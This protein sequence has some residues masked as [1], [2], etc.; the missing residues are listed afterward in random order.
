V[1]IFKF[2]VVFLCITC[3]I[4]FV[5]TATMIIKQNMIDMSINDNISFL[6]NK[7]K[8]K[9]PAKIKNNVPVIKQK[10]ASGY[11]C[12]EMLSKY[13][14]DD[15]AI[16]TEEDLYEENGNKISTSTNSGFYNEI[17]KQFPDYEIIQY[18]N[19][20][21]SEFIDKIYDSLL[22]DMPVICPYAAVDRENGDENEKKT[23]KDNDS[24]NQDNSPVWSMQYCIVVEMDIPGDKIKVNNPYGY[25]ETYTLKDFLKATRFE[26]YEN[27]DFYLKLGFAVEVFTKNTV[28]ILE[29]L[30]IPGDVT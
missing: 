5:I 7:V 2:S 21:N 23:D 12:I 28:Y 26:S 6:T 25:T 18:K 24:E 3:S 22:N 16:I 29:K 15:S 1:K 30:E 10:I 27:M 19:I 9:N 11:A 17:N 20:K 13:L 8:Y 4:C 14:R